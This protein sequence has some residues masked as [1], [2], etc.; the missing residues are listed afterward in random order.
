MASRGTPA[1]NVVVEN[2]L[3]RRSGTKSMRDLN[4]LLRPYGVQATRRQ[5]DIFKQRGWVTRPQK[6]SLGRGGRSDVLTHR[7]VEE[8]AIL[9]Q[10]QPKQRSREAV[11]E[12][13]YIRGW[14]L[15]GD[16]GAEFLSLM[17]E[18]ADDYEH[19]VTL[20]RCEVPSISKVAAKVARQPDVMNGRR[21]LRAHLASLGYLNLDSAIRD[22][23]E[24][25]I[26]A[27]HGDVAAAERAAPV[28]AAMSG[29]QGPE[30]AER[31]ETGDDIVDAL[32]EVPAALR[33][34]SAG[35]WTL[36]QQA[37]IEACGGQSLVKSAPAA[38]ALEHGVLK[39]LIAVVVNERIGNLSP[40]SAGVDTGR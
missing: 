25:V 30:A 35:E 14:P 16:F 39:Q 8:V 33:A 9:L 5:T 29:Q 17:S 37:F 27:T 7:Y 36:L 40:L 34:T 3:A 23:L 19:A 13:G 38:L 20:L 4:D 1:K 10:L 11:L 28:L 24:L 18:L 6:R 22:M 15:E 31:F 21:P 26:H 12:V 2:D 32:Q